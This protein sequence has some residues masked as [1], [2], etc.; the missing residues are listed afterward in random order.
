MA[1]GFTP[2]MYEGITNVIEDDE[3]AIKIKI[4]RKGSILN[5]I[6]TGCVPQIGLIAVEYA[7]GVVNWNFTK[8]E[9]VPHTYT[10]AVIKH[11][12]GNLAFAIITL[13][14]CQILVA[15]FYERLFD[16]CRKVE[17]HA[18]RSGSICK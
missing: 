9:A 13:V 11:Q 2:F 15:L 7:R 4:W 10:N 14:S 16:L 17:F 1:P 18:G 6:Y 12:Y 5:A 8:S 3:N